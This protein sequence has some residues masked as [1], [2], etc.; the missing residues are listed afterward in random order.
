MKEVRNLNDSG[1]PYIEV[2]AFI[3]FIP[4]NYFKFDILMG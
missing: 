1:K 2:A 4:I 3:W